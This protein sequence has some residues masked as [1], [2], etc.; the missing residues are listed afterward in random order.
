MYPGVEVCSLTECC[1]AP[2]RPGCIS[3]VSWVLVCSLTECCN[4]RGRPGSAMYPGVEVRSLMR[5]LVVNPNY[6]T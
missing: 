4:S 6:G 3:D 1:N 5:D 2:G